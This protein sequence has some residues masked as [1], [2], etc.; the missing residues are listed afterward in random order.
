M[1]AIPQKAP[2]QDLMLIKDLINYKDKTIGTTTLL[3]FKNHLWY[4]AP[5]TAAMA[6]FDKSLSLQ[7]KRMMLAA[8]HNESSGDVAKKIVVKDMHSFRNLEIHDFI[9]ED[10]F[11]M[12]DRLNIPITFL[13][14]DPE[15]WQA[16]E[17]FQKALEYVSKL[18]VVNDTAERGVKLMTDYNNLLT[19]DENEKQIILQI[20]SNYRKTYQDCTK[21]SMSKPF[22]T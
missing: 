19:H 9:N 22:V 13:S 1:T 11:K 17:D 7:S 14:T 5:E 4:I 10:S 12:F 2:L 18:K 6:F 16:N 20:I 8:L 21:S 15:L 3:K